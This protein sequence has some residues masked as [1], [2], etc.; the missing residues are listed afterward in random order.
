[1]S[2]LLERCAL[3]QLTQYKTYIQTEIKVSTLQL[4]S[5]FALVYSVQGDGDNHQQNNH[6]INFL[7]SNNVFSTRQFG[8][9]HG[10]S[11]ADLLTSLHHQ[12]LH[13][14]GEKGAARILAIDIAG[15]FDRVSHPGVLHN[16]P[17]HKQWKIV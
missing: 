8:F 9:R 16:F 2:K 13:T 6:K 15:A 1:M 14:A 3:E 4:P 10:H 7:E 5:S 12:W 11:A 17:F